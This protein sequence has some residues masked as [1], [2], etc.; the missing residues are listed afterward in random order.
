M[1]GCYFWRD[2]LITQ[3]FSVCLFCGRYVLSI[4]VKLCAAVPLILKSFI[5]FNCFSNV[6][7]YGSCCMRTCEAVHN[8]F[9]LLIPGDKETSM[10]TKPCKFHEENMKGQQKLNKNFK[11]VALR[12]IDLN[13]SRKGVTVREGTQIFAESAFG[14]KQWSKLGSPIR[15][16]EKENP[17]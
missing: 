16:V 11:R 5:A 1:A 4:T 9:L 17:S 8:K 14:E 7:Y 3:L 10:S 6:A 12:L 13:H 2:S 15:G